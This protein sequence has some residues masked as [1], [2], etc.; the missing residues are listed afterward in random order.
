MTGVEQDN[1]SMKIKLD[2]CLVDIEG[3]KMFKDSIV[4]GKR[5]VSKNEFQLKDVCVNALMAN[6]DEE[7]IDGNEKMKR[8]LLATKIQKANELDLK[9][10]EIVKLKEQ[11]GKVYGTMIV[12]QAYQMLEK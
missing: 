2:K 8:Y 3:E 11:I 1:K 4:D 12:G 10:E 9:S 6:V 7:K 5:V